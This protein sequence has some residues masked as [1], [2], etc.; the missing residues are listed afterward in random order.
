[1]PSITRFSPKAPK[2]TFAPF[3]LNSSILLNS[4]KLTCLCHLPACAS[5]SIP[6]SSI[7]LASFISFFNKFR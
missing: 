3:F 6:K 5:F 4:N 1:M 7:N 2:S